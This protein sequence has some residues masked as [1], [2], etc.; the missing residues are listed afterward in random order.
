ME[1]I[2]YS[3]EVGNRLLIEETNLI[4]EQGKI[5]HLL[6]NNGVGKSCFAKSCANILPHKG[7]IKQA[8]DLVVIGSYSNIPLDFTLNNIIDIIKKEHSQKDIDEIISLLNFD[9]IS[10]NIRIKQLSDG[11]KQKIKLLF[12]LISK[13]NNIILDEFTSS[14][15]KSSSFEL[16]SFFNNYVNNKNVTCINIT[17]NLADMENM[18]GAYFLL[19]NKRIIKYDNPNEIISRY[20]KGD[21]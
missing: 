1:L 17:H 12:F 7:T 19:S 16:Y 6:G 3:L 5:N 4:F 21:Y 20:I 10:K 2:N 13:P 18:P 11:Q 8:N 14:L 9:N 15:D